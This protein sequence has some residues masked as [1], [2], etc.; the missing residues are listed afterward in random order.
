MI[1]ALGLYFMLV[2]FGIVDGQASR[3]SNAASLGR[4]SQ[5]LADTVMN[6]QVPS[7]ER[8]SALTGLMRLDFAKAMELAPALLSEADEGLRFRAAWILADGGKAVGIHVLRT[9]AADK[10][11]DLT[12]PADALGRLRDRESHK[13][14]RELLEAE[15]S[16][17]DKMKARRRVRAMSSGLSEYADPGDAA[18][19][20]RAVARYL[21]LGAG[22]LE[23]QELGLTGSREA[24][25]LL[26]EIFTAREKGWA[27]ISAGLGLARCGSEM[28]RKYVSERLG[29]AG[30]CRA[31]EGTPQDGHKD[32]P[33]SSRATSFLLD[34]LGIAK[35]EIFVPELLQIISNANFSDTAKTQAWMA[36]S[37]INSPR[38]RQQTIDLAWRHPGERGAA[39]LI[40][41]NDEVGAR[42]RLAEAAQG[43]ESTEVRR[44]AVKVANALAAPSRERRRWR[45]IRGY[46]F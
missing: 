44:N 29:D 11:S 37:R 4:R 39:R 2:L 28:G 20:V 9:M 16:E 10:A 14:L 38:Y 23:A 8:E 46:A 43:K 40:A 12:L 5:E 32:D 35:D 15:L 7:P 22:W 33:Y 3:S 1:K 41:L 26:E 13:L 6:H 21:D 31:P 18:L 25:P 45:E 34:Q 19:L 36:L 42:R 30:C 17:P 27:V 24:I